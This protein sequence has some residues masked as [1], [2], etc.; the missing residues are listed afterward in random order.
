MTALEA[1]EKATM[2]RGSCLCGGIRFEADA[3]L[4]K[5]NALSQILGR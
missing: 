3:R 2:V 4:W 5:L 1:P